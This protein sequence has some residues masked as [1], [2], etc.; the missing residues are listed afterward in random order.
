MGALRPHQQR[1][2]TWGGWNER[3]GRGVVT[4]PLADGRSGESSPERITVRG[5]SRWRNHLHNPRQG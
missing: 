4:P 2:K 5:G 3:P 1:L